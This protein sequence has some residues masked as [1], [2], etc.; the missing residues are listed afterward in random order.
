M[1]PLLFNFFKKYND[2]HNLKYF[3]FYNLN[4]K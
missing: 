4:Y 3:N 1:R 2:I